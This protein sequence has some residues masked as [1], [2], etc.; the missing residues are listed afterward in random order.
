MENTVV[1][2]DLFASNNNGRVFTLDFGQKKTRIYDGKAVRTISHEEV[3]DLPK[4][5]G[6]GATL[7][8]EDS[9]MG[10]PRTE[11]SLAQ[12]YTKTE[13]QN[14]YN[15]CSINGITLKLFPQ[16]SCPRAL[17]YS[18]LEKKDENDPIAIYNLYRDFPDI[19]MKKPDP[20]FDLSAAAQ[21][22]RK[23]KYEVNSMINFA[24]RNGYYNEHDANGQWVIENINEIHD[25]LSD[26]GK[27]VF[28][29]FKETARHKRPNKNRNI[30]KGDINEK[31]INIAQIYP[32]LASMRGHL[33]DMGN[34]LFIVDD[35][36]FL[37]EATGQL[38]SWKFT[39]RF[40]FHMSP[41]HLKG[42][43]ARSNLYHWGAPKWIKEQA[44]EEGF[45]LDGKKRGQFTAEEDA[46]FLKYRRQYCNA[47]KELYN[48][49]KGMLE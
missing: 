38:P 29:F 14:F 31:N 16:K 7:I 47:I 13:L 11:K 12:P 18:N 32:I 28:G 1:Q 24:R 20:N 40:V 19:S 39:Q 36:L 25:S 30:K 41:Y 8:V 45:D 6:V 15:D 34:D 23:R 10:V 44:K 49:M 5:L 42:G 46:V 2:D 33:V 48:I 43:V 3:L 35:G 26:I 27:S 37:R 4:T 21:E 22:G 17:A 9:H